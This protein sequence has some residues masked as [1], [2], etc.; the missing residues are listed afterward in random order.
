M[1]GREIICGIGAVCVAAGLDGGDGFEKQP[2]RVAAI[3]G[4]MQG[5]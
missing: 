4:V 2:K 5:Y 3:L 1:A